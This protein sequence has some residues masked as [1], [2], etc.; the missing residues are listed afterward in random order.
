MSFALWF[1]FRVLHYG[2]K[3]SIQTICPTVKAYFPKIHITLSNKEKTHVKQVDDK[4]SI[5]NQRS[6]DILI[7]V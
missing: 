6:A 3:S 2:H 5:S 7:E 1:T 4:S